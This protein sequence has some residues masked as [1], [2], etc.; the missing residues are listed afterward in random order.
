MT[1]AELIEKLKEFP[2]DMPVGTDWNAYDE[3]EVTVSVCE[4]EH[5]YHEPFEYVN[6]L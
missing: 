3:I 6:I 4:S 2:Q 1:V 5:G